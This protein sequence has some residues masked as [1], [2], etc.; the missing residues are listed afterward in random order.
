MDTLFRKA[1]IFHILIAS[2]LSSCSSDSSRQAAE[3]RPP[4]AYQMLPQE[5]LPPPSGSWEVDTV[6]TFQ[7]PP[8][9]SYD[10]RGGRVA[11]IDGRLVLTLL[12]RQRI[13][14]Y[15]WEK[16]QLL[17]EIKLQKEGPHAMQRAYS[18]SFLSSDS[19]WVH[20]ADYFRFTLMD[21]E[22]KVYR[23]VDLGK[24]ASG[25]RELSA[26]SWHHSPIH[27]VGKQMWFI[28][29]PGNYSSAE[30]RYTSAQV[31][32]AD[33]IAG[34][35][36][37]GPTPT[38]TDLP[39]G[40]PAEYMDK[41][42]VYP[43]QVLTYWSWS[44]DTVYIS[45]PISARVSFYCLGDDTIFSRMVPSVP[46]AE[47]LQPLSPVAQF[48]RAKAV[49]AQ[50]YYGPV[51][52]DPWNQ[53]VYRLIIHPQ[54]SVYTSEG[55]YVQPYDFTYSVQVMDKKLRLLGEY[56]IPSER[57]NSLYAFASPDGLCLTHAHPKHPDLREEEIGCT[58]YRWL[59][60]GEK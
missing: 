40:F 41:I 43:D 29:T 42:W 27:A 28:W 15:D 35:V 54:T 20:G 16:G 4:A 59:A 24:S 37:L 5:E 53:L 58:C 47:V 23:R 45:H 26:Y 60:D 55:T 39:L 11:K 48:D 25:K 18:T 6:R 36:A 57:Y 2:I 50:G 32:P 1:A 56:P 33:R 7:A 22:G 21:G 51:R 13:V 31:M 38:A 19:L 14:Q 44:R 12:Y 49:L 9:L 10:N 8:G 34:Q 30:S 52:Y 46:L 3:P 17:R